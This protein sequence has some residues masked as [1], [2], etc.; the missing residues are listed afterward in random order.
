M[1]IPPAVGYRGKR[2]LDVAIAVPTLILA[3]P[4]MAVI[5]LLVAWRMGRPV[6]F[7][8]VRAG[9]NEQPFILYKFRSM[10][11]GNAPDNQ[12]LTP[13]GRFLRATSLDEL[14]E[15]INVVRGEMSLVGPRPLLDHYLPVYTSRERRRHAVRPGLT[16]WVQIHGRNVVPWDERLELDVWYVEH[17]SLRLDLIILT[18]TPGAVLHRTGVEVDTCREGDLRERRTMLEAGA[19]KGGG[20]GHA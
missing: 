8:Q 5:A 11:S 16:G 20:C 12:R 15:L 10:Q 7:R 19:Q 6:I 4:L 1:R 18:R 3:S 13:L 9:L 14:P 2:L 17:C